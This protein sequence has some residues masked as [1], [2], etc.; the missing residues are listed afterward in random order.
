MRL[1]IDKVNASDTAL[2]C[3][4]PAQ[5]GQE[6]LSECRQLRPFKRSLNLNS[7]QPPRCE[8][9]LVVVVHSEKHSPS[10]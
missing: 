5:S 3:L 10:S 1:T 4:Q 7:I 2:P 6:A 9:R 8:T